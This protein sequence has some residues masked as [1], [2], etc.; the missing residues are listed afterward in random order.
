MIFIESRKKS[1]KTLD[2]NYPKAEIIDLTSKGAEP[3]VKLSPFYPH[4]E[5]PVPFTEG[6]FS[7]SVEGIWQG[8]KTF[9]DSDI[10]TSKFEIQNMKDIKRTVRKFGKPLGHRQGV[11]GQLLDYL[12]ARQQI[13]LPSYDW[14]LE[15]KV[16]EV[17][18][19][20]KIKGLSNDLVFLDYQTNADI[21][22]V[23]KPISHAALVKK[24]LE[25]KYPELALKRFTQPDTKKQ[26][27]KTPTKKNKTQKT[28]SKGVRPD[29]NKTE[30]IG[31]LT[32]GFE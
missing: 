26:T 8:L 28:D 17:I 31:Q 20:L 9:Q 23:T 19:L 1:S 5:I 2:K 25:K 15:N 10:D 3:F 32:I 16:P 21:E 24:H 14:V 30:L 11:Q 29:K 12:T 22:D 4:G 18:D 6:V 27:R 13:Y 7:F